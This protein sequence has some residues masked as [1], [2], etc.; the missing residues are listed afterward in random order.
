MLTVAAFAA[1]P[2]TALADDAGVFAAYDARQPTELAAAAEKYVNAARRVRRTDGSRRAY[3]AVIRADNELNA[4]L[5][6]IGGEV[7]AQTASTPAGTA[8]REAALNEVQAWRRANTLEI[9]AIRSALS[10]RERR[11]RRILR[12]ANRSFRAAVRHGKTAVEQFAAAG[13]SSPNGPLTG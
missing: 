9:R 4:V 6:T 7:A 10:G 8:A 3:R 1:A 11:A 13:L 5:G 12:G 2:S